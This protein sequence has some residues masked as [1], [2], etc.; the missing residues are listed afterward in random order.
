MGYSLCPQLAVL[1]FI[2]IK[3]E[4]FMSQSTGQGLYTE[5][6]IWHHLIRMTASGGLGLLALFAVDLA[7]L[8][9]IGLIGEQA[10][11]AAVGFAGS[12]MFFTQ[13]LSIG[14]SIA[15][16]A[17][18]SRALGKNDRLK[19][20]E[21]VTSGVIVVF[22]T[23]LV[24]T[25]VVWIYR[26]ALLTWLGAEGETLTLAS[27]YLAIILPSFPFLAVGMAAGGVMRAQGDAKAA[28]WL[29]LSGALVNAVLDPLLIFGLDMGLSG[30]A[31]AS[32]F[33][34]LTIFVFGVY[35]ILYSYGLLT[36]PS[37]SYLRRDLPELTA[38]AVPSVL[39][40]LATP[41]GL[42]YVTATMAQYGDAAVAGTAIIGRLQMVA[43]VG[44][45]ALSSVVG[46]IAGQ[47]WGALHFDRVSA[48]FR[49]ALKFV[50][51]YCL[52][53]SA[54]LALSTP[55]I[56]IAFPVS[57]E[58]AE[59]IR[60]FTYGLS[61]VYLFNGATFVTNA[62]FNNLGAPKASTVFNIAKATLFTIPFVWLGS[63]LGGAPGVLIGQAIG[64]ALVAI[65]G[66][67]WAARW[68]KTLSPPR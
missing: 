20:S 50:A 62:L 26:L 42:A 28:L 37:L 67:L 11:A 59:L 14:L 45:F 10:L 5:G 6:S 55:L 48:V 64:A 35:M 54:V 40:N 25:L 60:L 51:L 31:V 12:I 43:F 38:I 53:A 9:F 33:S 2:I 36:R 29:T 65:V 4:I 39:T 21:L 68:L 58:S 17:T 32:V 47:N 63:R 57:A 19:A 15:V 7:D 52:V 41:I 56:R 27:D 8:F 3:S 46:P 30:A 24:L 49:D 22:L 18:V 1:F 44:L 61:L 66:V 16:G 13:S 23:S 34:R